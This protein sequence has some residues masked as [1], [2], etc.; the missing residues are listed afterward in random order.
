[1]GWWQ[2][3]FSFEFWAYV[4][5]QIY[6]E[7]QM[8]E[9]PEDDPPDGGIPNGVAY[10][11][12]FSYLTVILVGVRLLPTAKQRGRWWLSRREVDMWGDAFV[13]TGLISIVGLGLAAMKKWS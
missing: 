2:E 12:P 6:L 7:M 11:A 9:L 13:W 4:G 1:M 8:W 3:L 5:W 10:A